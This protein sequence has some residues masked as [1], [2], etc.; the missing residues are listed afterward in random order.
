MFP[1]DELIREV[2]RRV[3][4]YAGAQYSRP[5]VFES[6]RGRCWIVQWRYGPWG[7]VYLFSGGFPIVPGVVGR[8]INRHTLLVW[9]TTG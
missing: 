3:S 9:Q 4:E 6:N 2:V 5:D 7:W 1:R 8:R